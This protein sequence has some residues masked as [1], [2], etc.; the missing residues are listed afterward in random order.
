MDNKLQQKTENGHGKAA[1][2]I[3]GKG[4]YLTAPVIQG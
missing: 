3:S 2:Q 1:A 4:S